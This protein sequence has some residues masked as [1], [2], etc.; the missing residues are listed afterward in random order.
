MKSNGIHEGKDCRCGAS[1]MLSLKIN[2]TG[3]PHLCASLKFHRNFYI[4]VFSAK[5]STS[6][7]HELSSNKTSGLQK[8]HIAQFNEKNCRC[9][10][11]N[12]QMAQLQRTFFRTCPDNQ[13]TTDFKTN[14]QQQFLSNLFCCEVFVVILCC[15]LVGVGR[16]TG[17]LVNG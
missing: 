16:Q 10:N 4:F 2:H 1:G 15:G 13:S 5:F 8:E 12:S 3:S 6:S 9:R 17:S 14:G 11:C 7:S